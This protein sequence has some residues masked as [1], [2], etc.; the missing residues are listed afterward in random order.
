VCHGPLILQKIKIRKLTL[1]RVG[2]PDFRY[3]NA[4]TTSACFSKAISP[5]DKSRVE[6]HRKQ[7]YIPEKQKEVPTFER[8]DI[9]VQCIYSAL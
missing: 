2:K 6:L 8:T 4:L 9:T 3:N 7:S 5:V 1:R